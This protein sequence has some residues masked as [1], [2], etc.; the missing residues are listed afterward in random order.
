MQ[1]KKLIILGLILISLN[2]C[3]TWKF[4]TDVEDKNVY[5]GPQ[6]PPV[7]ECFIHDIVTEEDLRCL[8]YQ[9][10][11]YKTC[12]QLHEQAWEFFKE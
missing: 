12:I 5:E 9:K 7:H 11:S 2:A 4:W 6:C 8:A 3:S 1:K 10:Q